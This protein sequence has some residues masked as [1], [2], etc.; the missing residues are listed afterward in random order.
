MKS[1]IVA[2]VMCLVLAGCTQIPDSGPVEEVPVSAQPRSVEIAPE[3]PQPGVTP[4]RLVEGYLLAM[5]DPDGGYE[6]ARQYLTE[7]AARRWNPDSGVHVYDGRLSVDA[8]SVTLAGR[9]LGE[10][11]SAGRFTSRQES[12]THDFGVVQVNGQ[13]RI[14]IPPEGVLLTR[15]NFQRYY[16]HVPIYYLARN[17]GWVVPD[18]VHV[19]ESQLTISRLVQA[20]LAG[21]SESL[22]PVVRNPASVVKKGS[23]VSATV[24]ADGIANV[25]LTDL[26][27]DL[28]DDRRREVVAQLLW[29][30]TAI[31]RIT[32]L[33]I[34]TQG[35][36]WRIPGQ[37]AAGVVDFSSQ[38][39]YQ[40]LSRA[41]SPDLYGIKDSQPGR[42]TANDVFLPFTSDGGLDDLQ[43]DGLAVSLDGSRVALMDKARRMVL[44][45]APEGPFTPQLPTLERLDHL[46][47]STDDLWILGRLVGRSAL[48]RITSS[49]AQSLVELDSI[50]GEVQRISVSQTGTHIA[51][52][53][54]IGEDS[55]VG[56]ATLDSGPVPSVSS[57]TPL[58]LS[59]GTDETVSNPI[60]VDWSTESQL[61]V[62]ADVGEHQTVLQVAMDGSRIEDLSLVGGRAVDVAALPRISGDAIV[63]LDAQG[64][65]RRFE[66]RT[67]WTSVNVNLD[68]LNYPG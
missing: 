13:W 50:P 29:T 64:N 49:G 15:Y 23:L 41:T 16:S 44:T 56:I 7:D 51:M 22:R 63:V 20:L 6:V 62:L 9:L 33:R 58:E 60:A 46:A 31:A 48:V 10:I 55:I 47:Y 53:T 30:L 4:G 11:D 45:G 27:A 36:Q 35:Q 38:Q 17:G 14:N 66:P 2:F 21:P 37:N 52:V 3:P 39:G 54:R 1:R 43:F 68:H 8:A 67:R 12:L 28:P 65:V 59:T 42:I 5:T 25:E 18:P 19:P 32:G 34:T 40:V 26:P 61:V 24:D 57:W